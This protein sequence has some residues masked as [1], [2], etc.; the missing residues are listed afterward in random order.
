MRILLTKVHTWHMRSVCI[1]HVCLYAQLNG[2]QSCYLL[3][4]LNKQCHTSMSSRAD[5]K[6]PVLVCHTSFSSRVDAE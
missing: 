1:L 5:A 3:E 6:G 4:R 2:L